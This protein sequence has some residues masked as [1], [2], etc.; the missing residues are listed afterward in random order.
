MAAGALLLFSTRFNFLDL[1]NLL[2]AGITIGSVLAFV[3]ALS[4][5]G[6]PIQFAYHEMHGLIM[7]FFGLTVL[8]FCKNA[9]TLLYCT[10]FLFM[11]YAFSEIIFC[12]W[13]LK[14]GQRVV[15]K[16]VNIRTLLG[17][18]SGFSAVLALSY[19]ETNMNL[20]LMICGSIF[21]CIGLNVM[22]YIPVMKRRADYQAKMAFQ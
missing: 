5:P 21:V 13:L 7:L 17:I 4:R 14:L 3:T 22:L 20:A 1:K 6:K 15:Y 2:G 16:I 10:S 9:E 8:V 18:L 19:S 12:S 11:F